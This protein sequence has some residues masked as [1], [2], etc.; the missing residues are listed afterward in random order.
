MPMDRSR[1]SYF[2]VKLTLI[3]TLGGALFGYD[4]AVISGAITAI[5]A[6]FIDPL[7]LSE[8]A[9]SGLS[10][11]TISSALFGCI[12]GGALAGELADRFGRK[13]TLICAALLFLACSFGSALPELGLAPIGRL[14]PAALLSF[15][16]YRIAGGIGVGIASLVS[17]LYI[18]EIAPKEKRGKLVSFNQIAIVVGIMLVYFVNWAIA[19]LGDHAWLQSW[20]WR[21]MFASEAVPSLL[22]LTLLLQATET[23]RWM[24]MRGRS[25]DAAHLLRS[26]GDPNPLGTLSEIATSLETGRARLFAFGTAVVTIGILLAVLQQFIGIN[27]V[28]YY[29]PLIF[30]DM[31]AG[32]DSAL[33]QTAF[34]GVTNVAFTLVATFTVDRIGRRPL[35]IGGALAMS[36]SMLFLGSAFALHRLGIGALLSIMIYTAAFALSWGPVTWVL[37]TEIFPN[38]IKSTALSIAVAAQWISNLLVSWSFRVL[39]GNSTLNNA[40]NHGFAYWLYGATALSAAWLVWRLVPETKGRSLE[41]IQELW[42]TAAGRVTQ[43][44]KR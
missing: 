35:M 19:R 8:A 15:N 43:M 20:G 4:T 39:D 30:R 31:G 11:L 32:T 33:L 23:P 7:R 25:K 2:T 40:F 1:L 24:M 37:L 36:G 6:N 18:A 34:I 16:L 13:R 10:G 5:D 44:E 41:S 29:A 26:L 42:P 21:W 27:A 28:M 9:R 3:A 14:G 17:P 12:I 38:S 22:F